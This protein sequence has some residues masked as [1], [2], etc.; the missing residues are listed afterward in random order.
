[1]EKRWYVLYHTPEGK[2]VTRRLTTNQ[3]L[4][5]LKNEHF[6]RT[7]QASLTQDDYRFL[8]DYP[9]FR[10]ALAARKLDGPNAREDVAGATPGTLLAPGEK[11]TTRRRWRRLIRR[12]LVFLAVGALGFWLGQLLVL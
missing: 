2:W 7:A 1:E 5:S 6:A 10:D 9:E 12:A 11:S 4:K 3:V 8:A